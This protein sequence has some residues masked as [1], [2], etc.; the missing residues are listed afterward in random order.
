MNK[1]YFY[2]ILCVNVSVRFL[3][4][5]F[6]YQTIYMRREV[7]MYIFFCCR[8]CRFCIDFCTCSCVLFRFYRLPY[9]TPIEIDI[10]TK[11]TVDILCSHPK[12][13]EKK[14]N[15]TTSTFTTAAKVDAEG[16][17]ANGTTNHRVHHNLRD[18][19]TRPGSSVEWSG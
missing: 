15:Q 5:P 19:I 10:L 13:Q 12:N 3:S 8:R 9:R 4:F 18:Y 6:Q 2:C 11:Y 1:I 17:S 7:N 16:T 14:V